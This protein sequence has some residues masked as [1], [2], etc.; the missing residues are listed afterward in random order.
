MALRIFVL[1]LIMNIGYWASAQQKTKTPA[2]KSKATQRAQKE[3]PPQPPPVDVLEK[4]VVD[5]G[6]NY[7]SVG[8]P[9]P[10]IDFDTT[11]A[12]D[13]AFTAKIIELL[14][15]TNT[16]KSNIEAAEK[17]LAQSFAGQENNPMV[18]AFRSRFLADLQQGKT[19]RWL[20][21]LYIRKYRAIFTPEEVDA[22]LVFYRTPAG[23]KTM[24]KQ[25]QF[26]T[27]VVIDSQK[28]GMYM[29]QMLMKDILKEQKN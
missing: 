1:F 18:R 13:D 12:P 7:P 8:M 28:I 26:A 14:N 4:M 29:G 24:K 9:D 16:T 6:S 27:E 21:N 22:L 15:L 23:E 2:A 19:S 11:E 5:T 17:S 20:R 3:L 25:I 10:A